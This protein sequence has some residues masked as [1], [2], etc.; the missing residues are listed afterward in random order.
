MKLIKMLVLTLIILFGLSTF[1]HAQSGFTTG[2]NPKKFALVEN[3]VTL[4]VVYQYK[5]RVD[6]VGTD[7]DTIYTEPFQLWNY[8]ASLY[9]YPIQGTVLLSS[10]T[11]S[12]RKL[13]AFLLGCNTIAGTYTV[14]D[15]LSLV[16]S[17]STVLNKKLNMN[18]F[19]RAYYKL[20]IFKGSAANKVCTFDISIYAYKRD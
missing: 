16:D 15:T 9:T 19:Q 5:G 1:V 12:T 17:A 6:T 8:D 13:S 3:G 7:I 11:Q 10:G 2:Y 20:M 4:G 14:I 18:G